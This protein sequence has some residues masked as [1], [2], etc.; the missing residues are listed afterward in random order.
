VTKLRFRFIPTLAL[1]ALGIGFHA[2]PAAAS[3]TQQALFEDDSAIKGDPTGTLATFRDLGVTRAR[4]IV[5]WDSIAPRPGSFKAPKHFTAT[6]PASYPAANWFIYDTI[7][8]DAQADGIALDFTLTGP[9]P[10]WATGPGNP[11]GSG[12][13]HGQWKPSA[14]QF[15]AFA[16]AIGTRYS[17]A[18]TP[19]GATQPLPRV[20]FWSIWNEPN[21]GPDLAPQAVNNDTIEVSAPEYR[22]L[23]DSAWSGLA[24]SGHTPGANDTIL[25]GETAPRGLDHP[26][27]NFSGIKPLRF[28]RALYCVDSSYHQLRGSAASARGCPTTA[29]GSRR[30]AA[31]NPA[32]FQA[33][34]LADHPYEQ[35]TPPNRPTYL[36]NGNNLCSGSSDPDFADLPEIPRLERFLDRVQ[37]AYGAHSHMS[38]WSTEYGYRT[39]PPDPHPNQS[40][41]PATAAYYMNWAE[42]LSWRQARIGSYMQYL[43]IDGRGDAFQS[44][45]E[46]P[47]GRHKPSYDAYR[48]PLYLPATSTRRGRTLEV[49]GCVRPAHFAQLDT[50][51]A[52]QVA[53]Q[54]RRGSRGSFTTVKTVTVT[55]QR[56]YFDVRGAF[57]A[58]GAVRLAWRYPSGDPMLPGGTI[59]SRTVTITVR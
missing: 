27:G 9:A 12:Y 46:F 56:G 50:G 52:Q 45:L 37:G 7:V 32:L 47:N 34:G 33:G 53:I 22:G 38:V 16:Q 44:G 19:R 26:I 4:L 6:N 24:A 18:Y 31:Q 41:S 15:G 10:L 20:S 57:P 21:Y 43:L 35:A 8:R 49:W 5:A 3:T 28:L 42:Y 11:H 54:F 51:A 25:I 59:Y 2:A 39:D 17:G 36:C 13:P 1:L 29:A 40:V 48:M 55:N 14:S 30:F 58:S 23:L